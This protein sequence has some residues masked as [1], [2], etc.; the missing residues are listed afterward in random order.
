MSKRPPPFVPPEVDL[1]G[2]DFMPLKGDRLF[3][4]K[5]WIEASGEACKAMLRLYWQ[6]YAHEAP[7]ASLPNS[8]RLLAQHAGYGS[9]VKAWLRVRDQAMRGWV[10]CSDG[11]WYH[12]VLAELALSAW[13][14]RVRNR[15]KV[16]QW[17]EK[18]QG[19]GGAVTGTEPLRNRRE[20][21]GQLEGEII[22]GRFPNKLGA[23]ARAA[24]AAAV[25]AGGDAREPDEHDDGRSDA[26]EL[27]DAAPAPR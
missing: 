1:R 21:E 12:K 18:K 14:G 26:N 27:A 15:E 19:F 23:G 6:A 16:R 7:A 8:E 13:A 9:A 25:F 11:R 2:M 24:L 4:S 5:T 22:N 10:L 3:N 20:G 17:R